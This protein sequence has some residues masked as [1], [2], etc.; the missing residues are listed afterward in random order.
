MDQS[1][2]KGQCWLLRSVSRRPSVDSRYEKCYDR[3]FKLTLSQYYYYNII[4]IFQSTDFNVVGKFNDST[5]GHSRDS[6]V[7][8]NTVDRTL[9]YFI[10]V[11]VRS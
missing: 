9:L 1:G 3:C 8:R 4:T 6:I 10:T 7:L 2:F 11:L 5:L